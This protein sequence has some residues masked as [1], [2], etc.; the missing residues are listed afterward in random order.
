M[1]AKLMLEITAMNE[2]DFVIVCLCGYVGW[3]F[4]LTVVGPIVAFICGGFLLQIYTHFDTIDTSTSVYS[5]TLAS[6]QCLRENVTL[7]SLH[8]KTANKSFSVV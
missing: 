6:T 5:C 4:A 3:V 2:F 8:N 1:F 7:F